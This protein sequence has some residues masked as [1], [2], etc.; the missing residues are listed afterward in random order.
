M[1]LQLHSLNNWRPQFYL[2]L[3]FRLA[4]NQKKWENAVEVSTP[5]VMPEMD[6]E[7]EEE[8]DMEENSMSTLISIIRDLLNNKE[9]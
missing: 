4:G 2:C 9:K 6:D 8:D 5:V 1:S 3:S 7:Y